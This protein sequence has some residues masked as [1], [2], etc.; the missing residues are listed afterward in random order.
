VLEH[1]DVS[2]PRL[3]QVWLELVDQG[4]LGVQKQAM[5]VLIRD[6]DAVRVFE[7][8]RFVEW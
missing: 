1:E 5:L 3:L 6:N 7:V 8:A 2:S 4:V